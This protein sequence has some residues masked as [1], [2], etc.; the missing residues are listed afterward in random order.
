[1]R[2]PGLEHYLRSPALSASRAAAVLRG[3]FAAMFLGQM[4]VALVLA[5]L[6]RLV[7]DVQA[8]PSPLLG[9]VLVALAALEL[10]VGLML[11]TVA[12]RGNDRRR[13]LSAALVGAVVLSTPAWFAALALATAQGGPPV[14]VLWG[15]L[16]AYYAAGVVGIGR[17]AGR[18]VRSPPWT[19]S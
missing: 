2:I 4:L 11:V 7:T 14:L 12:A 13:A 3:L 15:I 18:A 1:M 5:V 6:V 17:L 8:R 16:A 9:W 10:P 19:P